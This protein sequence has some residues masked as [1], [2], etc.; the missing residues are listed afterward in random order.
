VGD[1]VYITLADNSLADAA[2]AL[3]SGLVEAAYSK[4]GR[5]TAID[6]DTERATVNLNLRDTL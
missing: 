6:E 4:F 2:E 1:P 3:T 5:I